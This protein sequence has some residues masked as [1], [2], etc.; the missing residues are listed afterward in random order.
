MRLLLG[1]P[2]VGSCCLSLLGSVQRPAPGG[3][4]TSLCDLAQVPEHF[5]AGPSQRPERRLYQLGL[6][7]P[8]Q[9]QGS[10]QTS[11]IPCV[12]PLSPHCY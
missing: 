11:G 5:W 12:S 7:V 9:L 3:V 6:P 4:H 2:R 1:R 8:F 10:P